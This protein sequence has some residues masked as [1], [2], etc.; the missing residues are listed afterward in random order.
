MEDRQELLALILPPQ[1]R[2]AVAAAETAGLL[3]GPGLVLVLEHKA[4]SGSQTVAGLLDRDQVRQVQEALTHWLAAA[5]AQ[6][7]TPSLARLVVQDE[8]GAL[9]V[10]DSAT[11]AQWLPSGAEGM[12]L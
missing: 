10:I 7:A 12:D 9:E 6:P 8:D 4:A 11:V 1:G 5:E 2:L 3:P